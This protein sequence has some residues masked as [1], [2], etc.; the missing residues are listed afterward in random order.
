[1][2]GRNKDKKCTHFT[3]NLLM[4]SNYIK[5]NVDLCIFPVNSKVCY[6]DLQ[7]LQFFSFPLLCGYWCFCFLFSNLCR[8]IAFFHPIKLVKGI[9]GLKLKVP[10]ISKISI[11]IIDIE[12]D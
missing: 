7:D 10:L 8:I 3:F 11:N 9:N 1:M 12:K 6:L 2:I 5:Y 4:Y